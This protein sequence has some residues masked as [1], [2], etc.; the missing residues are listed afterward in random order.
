[1]GKPNNLEMLGSGP[2]ESKGFGSRPLIGASGKT[3]GPLK[4][5]WRH[6]P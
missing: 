2:K 1:M 4:D 6:L 5:E 3:Q